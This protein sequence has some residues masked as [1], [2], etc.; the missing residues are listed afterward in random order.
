MA[1]AA[2][3]KTQVR[4]IATAA[5]KKPKEEKEKPREEKVSVI[6]TGRGFSI[7]TLPDEQ[8]LETLALIVSDAPLVMCRFSE[9]QRRIMRDKQLGKAAE[10]RVA[11]VPEDEAKGAAHTFADGSGFGLPAPAFKAALVESARFVGTGKQ[12]VINMTYLKG[13]IRIMADGMEDSGVPLV[14]IMVPGDYIVR[15]DFVRNSSGVADIRYRPQ[16]DTWSALLRIAHA[17]NVSR[18]Q[19]VQLVRAAGRFNGIGEWRPM[20]KESKSGS[21]GTWRL[22][23]EEEII[24]FTKLRKAA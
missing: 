4:E 9:K 10:A 20:S 24:E 18:A 12:K 15:E 6:D 17:P 22:A 1:K 21:W 7:V 3:T 16:F 2:L 11:K 8:L 23:T 13:A 5:G 19:I 14:R